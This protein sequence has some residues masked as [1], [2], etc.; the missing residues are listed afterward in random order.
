MGCWFASQTLLVVS[1]SGTMTL[2]GLVASDGCGE[3]TESGGGLAET[4]PR[5]FYIPGVTVFC[6]L[7]CRLAS[8]CWRVKVRA[9][10]ANEGG[11][12]ILG[13]MTWKTSLKLMESFDRGA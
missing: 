2:D 13:R 3:T 6:V 8:P 10:Q 7:T 9:R 5:V 11:V 4:L 1:M 12:T